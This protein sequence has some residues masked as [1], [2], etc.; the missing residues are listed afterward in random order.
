MAVKKKK[1]KNGRKPVV[2]ALLITALVLI[3]V[4]A[5]FVIQYV[6]NPDADSMTLGQMLGFKPSEEELHQQLIDETLT[7]S[8]FYDGISIEGIDIG[9]MTVDQARN[10]TSELSEK[11]RSTIDM[12]IVYEDLSWPVDNSSFTITSDIEDILVEAFEIGHSGDREADFSEVTALGTNPRDFSITW[13]IACAPGQELFDDISA[14]VDSP[15]QDAVMVGFDKETGSLMSEPD[16]PGTMADIEQL[17]ADLAEAIASG[18]TTGQIALAVKEVPAAVTQADLAGKYML[19]GQFS[20]T[21]KKDNNRNHNI[22]LALE[23]FDGYILKPGETFSTNQVIGERTKAAGYKEAG[24]IQAGVSDVGLGGGVCQVSSTLFNAVVRAGFEL[25]ERVPHSWPSDYV[26]AG[27]DAMINWPDS[28]FKFKNTTDSDAYIFTDFDWDRENGG[29]RVLT[30]S[31]YGTPIYDPALRVDLRS[32]KTET[33]PQPE[34]NITY[35]ETMY[36]DEVAVQREGRKG[37]KYTTY[38]QFFDAEG[39][40]VEEKQLLNST[41]RAISTKIIVG[42][43]KRPAS[44]DTP[45]LP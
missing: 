27:M 20:T 26:G 45:I 18:N 44:F 16:I 3:V 17:K 13:D 35:V 37:A 39:N 28:D 1:K 14:Q 38:I 21:A 22:K 8:T 15:A 29:S 40:L 10:A 19:I 30:V 9:G 7:I 34:D 33:I 4:G 36:E 5:F 32:E 42:T 31:I 25:V 2:P 6:K 23:S 43:M 24:V 11:M 41:Y 12:K